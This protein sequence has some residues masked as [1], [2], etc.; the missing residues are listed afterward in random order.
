MVEK[1]NPGEVDA[2]K[3][4]SFS[5]L[6]TENS[7]DTIL[8]TDIPGN[9]GALLYS[10]W[11]EAI[12]KQSILSVYAAQEGLFLDN[13]GN[14]FNE[15]NELVTTAAIL[16]DEPDGSFPPDNSLGDFPEMRESEAENM[17]IHSFVPLGSRSGGEKHT[18]KQSNQETQDRVQSGKGYA[19]MESP[20]N[21][22]GNEVSPSWKPISPGRFSDYAS[23]R[24]PI[25]IHPF[26][27]FYFPLSTY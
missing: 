6:P 9:N 25:D 15:H 3:E 10:I 21:V 20:V 17:S 13:K 8:S 16:F 19:L 1:V 14:L 4:F 7:P 23:I 24:Y 22:R 12:Q 2:W 5:V 27:P 18:H 11:T 26:F